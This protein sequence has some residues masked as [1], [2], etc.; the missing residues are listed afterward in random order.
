MEVLTDKN[1]KILIPFVDDFIIEITNEE[2]IIEEI[3]GLR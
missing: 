2:I 3:E 1:T